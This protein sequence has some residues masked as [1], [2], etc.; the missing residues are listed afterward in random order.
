MTMSIER[1]VLWEVCHSTYCEIRRSSWPPHSGTG[2][3]VT[4]LVL[5]LSPGRKNGTVTRW[6]VERE[7]GA[8]PDGR[9]EYGWAPYGVD[10]VVNDERVH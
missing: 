2:R 8:A 4:G 7:G 6:H 9:F 10:A 3:E 1:T 5:P